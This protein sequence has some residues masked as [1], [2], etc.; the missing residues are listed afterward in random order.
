MSVIL[1]TILFYEALILQGEIWCW[2]LL[3]LEG[4]KTTPAVTCVA[5][6]PV[7]WG[8]RGGWT[9]KNARV[10]LLRGRFLF[11]FQNLS[12]ACYASLCIYSHAANT[13]WDYFWKEESGNRKEREQA[14]VFVMRCKAVAVDRQLDTGTDPHRFPPFYGNRSDFFIRNLFLIIRT[15]QVEIWKMVWTNVFFFQ[16]LEIW[17]LPANESETRESEL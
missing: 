1:M 10:L 9:H 17:C 8:V 6:A 15:F 16:F 14:E 12:G 11:G 5:D 2:S 7:I 13:S 4:L 3:G